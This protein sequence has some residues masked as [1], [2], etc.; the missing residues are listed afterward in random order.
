MPKIGREILT[1]DGVGVI[2]AI[3]VLSETVTVRLPVSDSFENRVYPIDAC[4]RLEGGRAAQTPK[5]EKTEETA[6]EPIEQ[7]QDE[8]DEAELLTEAELETEN[9]PDPDSETDAEPEAAEAEENAAETGKNGSGRSKRKR[10]HNR[11][12][13]RPKEAPVLETASP[14]ENRNQRP[15][16]KLRKGNRNPN[17]EGQRKQGDARP[18]EQGKTEQA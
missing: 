5:A 14:D 16:R 11:R 15:P 17:R 6:A 12:G 7:V 3:N 2:T 18:A 9:E 1:P 10:R 8:A 13:A 4:Q